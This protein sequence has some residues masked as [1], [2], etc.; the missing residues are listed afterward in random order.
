MTARE[1]AEMYRTY[2]AEEGFFPKIDEDGDVCFKFEGGNYYLS[3]DEND[4]E[5]FRLVFPNFWSI[6]SES[7]SEQAIKAAHHTTSTT[8]VAKVY[9]TRR[10]NTIASIEMF[11]DPPEVFKSVF[12]RSLSALQSSVM[13]FRKKMQEAEEDE[14][15]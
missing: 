2:L 6:D 12:R 5:Y 1:L 13:K 14:D 7:E 9:L 8:K 4:L 11:C 3:V 15:E 10:D